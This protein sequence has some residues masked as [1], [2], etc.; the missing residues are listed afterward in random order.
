MLGLSRFRAPTRISVACVAM[1]LGVIAIALSGAAV[2]Q[3]VNPTA[4]TVKP[5]GIE[6]GVGAPLPSSGGTGGVTIDNSSHTTTTTTITK[7][8]NSSSTTTIDRSVR[9]GGDVVMGGDKVMGDKIEQHITI[10]P[11]GSDTPGASAVRQH[12]FTFD[13]QRF[14]ESY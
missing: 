11:S 10:T 6:A 3:A 1:M 4:Q 13:G 2:A 12:C 14:C 8:D 5:S 7:I 9:A